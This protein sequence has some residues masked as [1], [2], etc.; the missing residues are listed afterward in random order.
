MDC[1]LVL[2]ARN[3]KI[4]KTFEDSGMVAIPVIEWLRFF[5][6]LAYINRESGLREIY[7]AIVDGYTVFSKTPIKRI[8]D[9]R[10]EEHLA[11]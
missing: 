11:A 7:C 5:E 4:L 3:R 8:V 10:F 2:L 9:F 6:T 1:P